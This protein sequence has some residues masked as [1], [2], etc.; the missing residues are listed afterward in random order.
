MSHQKV[1]ETMWIVAESVFPTRISVRHNNYCVACE[2]ARRL[3]REHHKK[4]I[5]FQAVYAAEIL[6]LVETKYDVDID[7]PF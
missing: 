4:F 6:D 2:E 5:V 3:A 1:E 7:I